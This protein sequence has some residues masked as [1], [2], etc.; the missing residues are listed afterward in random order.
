M[1]AKDTIRVDILCYR[2]SLSQRLLQGTEIYQELHEIVDEAVK[3]LEIGEGCLIGHDVAIGPGCIVEAGVR[4]SRCI[5]MQRAWI[6]K[7]ACI[8]GSIIG[9][10]S[11]VGQWAHVENMTILGED[12]HWRIGHEQ[13][14]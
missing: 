6:K 1:V 5:V 3:K 13:M 9:W 8:S 10:H 2:V 4:L 7:H 12:V 14:V 11:T